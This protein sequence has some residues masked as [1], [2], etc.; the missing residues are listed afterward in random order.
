[1]VAAVNVEKRAEAR[2]NGRNVR[3]RLGRETHRPTAAAA[4]KIARLRCQ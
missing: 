3:K 1:M 2:G 4:A